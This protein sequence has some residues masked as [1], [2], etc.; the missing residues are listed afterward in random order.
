MSITPTALT[1]IYKSSEGP[2]CKCVFHL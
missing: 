2:P 1:A